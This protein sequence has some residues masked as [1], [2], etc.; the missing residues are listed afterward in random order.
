MVL[1]SLWGSS[2]TKKH[3]EQRL[4]RTNPFHLFRIIQD[5]DRYSEFVPLCF[6]SEVLRRSNDGRYFDATL[7][8]GFPPLLTEHYVSRVEVDPSRLSVKARS[9]SSQHLE[10]LASRFL[11]TPQDDKG[12]HVDF[13]VEMTVRDPLIGQAL[14][15]V[16]Q[17]VAKQQ[18]EAF[19][20]RCHE[21]PV[22][23]S[24]S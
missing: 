14:D 6:H 1:G 23:D 8:V 12:V 10:A 4:I 18:V 15:R 22:E 21:L 19:E 3:V 9:I 17:D 13:Q 24:S 2:I 20:L 16:L 5:V 7:T 11:L